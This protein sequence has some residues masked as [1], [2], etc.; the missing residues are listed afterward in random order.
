VALRDEAAEIMFLLARATALHAQ[1]LNDP[2]KRDDELRE[3]IHVNRLAED[4]FPPNTLPRAL[5]DQRADLARLLGD[6]R[7][8]DRWTEKANQTALRTP[9]ER[10]LV[11][12][13]QALNGNLRQAL[14]FIEAVTRNDPRSFPARFV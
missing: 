11:A 1:A 5:F 6:D 2:A 12:H 4:C 7:E 9:R 13:Q 10:Y 14:T 3:A 8:T